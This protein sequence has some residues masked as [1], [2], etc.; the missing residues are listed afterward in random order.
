MAVY[1][2]NTF[3]SSPSVT[4]WWNKY[5]AGISQFDRSRVLRDAIR[6]NPAAYFKT[7]FNTHPRRDYVIMRKLVAQYTGVGKN[8]LKAKGAYPLAGK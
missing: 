7:F 1:T 4:A 8:F 6:P 2:P 5:F 3:D